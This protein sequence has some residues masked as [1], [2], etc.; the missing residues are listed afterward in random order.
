MLE[1]GWREAGPNG[2]QFVGLD[3]QDVRGDARAF[4]RAFR[5]TYLNI[6]EGD[7][8][9]ARR[10]GVTGLPETFFISSRGKIVSHVVGAITA[11]QLAPASP[12]PRRAAR[13]RRSWVGTVKPYADRDARPPEPRTGLHRR[14]RLVRLAVLPSAGPWLPG[15]GH[16][17][18]A[19]DGDGPVVRSSGAAAQPALRLDVLAHLR[20]ARPRRDR[21]RVGVV[22]EPKHTRQGG[23]GGHHRHGRAVHRL[24]LHHPAEPRVAAADS[25]RARRARRP[26]RRRSGLCAGLDAVRRPD[27]GGDP[28]TRLHNAGHGKRCAAADDLLRR[29]RAPVSLLGGR[30]HRGQSSP[31][32]SSSATT[33]RFRRSP[34]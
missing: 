26:D 25:H 30:V 3:M 19:R 13:P 20:P 16:G 5:I 22:C 4:L 7:N 1:R 11:K 6:R 2:V 29:A 18:R 28:R 32:A 34:G 33:R 9:T 27:V 23:W 14:V 21:D 17:R 24:A 12:R 10:Y 31:S 15:H 8:A